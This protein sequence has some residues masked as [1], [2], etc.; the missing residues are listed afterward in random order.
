MHKKRNT[1]KQNS[2]QTLRSNSDRSCFSKYKIAK[3]SSVSTSVS[4]WILHGVFVPTLPSINTPKQSITATSV[5]LSTS[6]ARNRNTETHRNTHKHTC[7]HARS[8][9]L[10]REIERD[11]K[12]QKARELER[13]GVIT[14]EIF[15]D[16]KKQTRRVVQ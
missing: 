7:T 6:I 10:A 13:G 14:T 9:E 15:I 1:S 12:R 4:M 5:L 8:E 11:R 3:R 2:C 16:I